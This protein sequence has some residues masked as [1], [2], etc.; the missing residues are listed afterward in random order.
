MNE[1][2][3][4]T[5]FVTLADQQME[6]MRIL[7]LLLTDDEARTQLSESQQV[8]IDHWL[9][10]M[11]CEAKRNLDQVPDMTAEEACHE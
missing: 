9:L 10:S 7:L 8:E 5:D 2:I 11:V 3:P 4:P 1:R 6:R